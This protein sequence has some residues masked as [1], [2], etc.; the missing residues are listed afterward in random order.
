MGERINYKTEK[1]IELDYEIRFNPNLT[2]GEKILY[3]ELK[4]LCNQGK[5]RYSAISLA[6]LIGVSS[7]SITNWV[8]KLCELNYIEISSY[9]DGFGKRFIKL[10]KKKTK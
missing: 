9:P 5:C 8:K 10:K 4:S 3:A 7:V 2:S 1:S 6:D